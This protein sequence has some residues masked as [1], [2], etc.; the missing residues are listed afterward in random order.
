MIHLRRGTQEGRGQ[1]VGT[2]PGRDTT[3]RD[4]G[5]Y[6]AKRLLLLHSE[7]KGRT[8]NFLL[9]FF[10]GIPALPST[11][12]HSVSLTPPDTCS[13]G[14]VYVQSFSRVQLFV[15]PCTIAHQAPL[16]MEFS[17]QE[18]GNG[19]PF[20]IPRDLTFI[21]CISPTGRQ[22]LYHQRHMGRLLF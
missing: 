12:T 16:P 9:F 7:P 6:K 3:H 17:R 8:V 11:K 4:E 18:Y 22:I 10:F 21:S 15:A 14:R 2:G 19:V 5:T 20:P 13:L 1:A